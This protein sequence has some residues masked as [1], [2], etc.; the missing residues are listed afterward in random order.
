MPEKFYERVLEYERQIDTLKHECPE[1]ILKALTNLYSDAIEYHGYLENT[2]KCGEL[3]MRM[4]SVLV[5]PHVLDCLAR[6]EAEAKQKSNKK[7]EASPAA[8]EVV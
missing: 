7:P 3:Q 5:K 2:Q 6:Y 1:A 4:Q 8:A